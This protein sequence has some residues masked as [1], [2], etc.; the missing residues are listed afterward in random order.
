MEAM[1]S[2]LVFFA[3]S[4]LSAVVA[5]ALLVWSIRKELQNENRDPEQLSCHARGMRRWA[6]RN[7]GADADRAPGSED[8]DPLP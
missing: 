8:R 3:A 4:I 2:V 7:A 1:F 5:T 6:A